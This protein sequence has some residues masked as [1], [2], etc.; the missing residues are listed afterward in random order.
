M[1]AVGIIDLVGHTGDFAEVLAVTA[2]ELA[3]EALGRRSK[4]TVIVLI[5]LAELVNAI[6]HIG[7][8]LDTQLLCLVT[9]AVV[10]ADKSNQTLGKADEADAQRALID[11][12]LH[13][14]V[15]L[16]LAGTVPQLRHEQGELL[17]HSR[18]LVLEAG[19][20]LT[21]GNFQQ[22]VQLGEESVDA[23]LLVLDFHALDSEL[24]DID[25]REREVA[26]TDRGL[27]AEAVLEH[28]GATTHRCHLVDVTFG[29]V[30]T[31]LVILVVGGIEVDE[32]GEKT[33]C[34]HL[35]GELVEV[36]VAVLRLIAHACFLLPDL[37]GEDGSGTVAH[38]LLGRVEQLADDAAPFSTDV[39]TLVDRAE[40]H[41][42]SATGVDRVHVVDE[43]LH[44]LMHTAHRLV[45]GMLQDTLVTLQEIQIALNEVV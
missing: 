39:G 19:I 42:V 5:A 30:D 34:R 17:G 6:T 37:N 40:H 41:L 45:D 22:V 25:G 20:K 11:D 1:V 4:N 9:L 23:F 8:D 27:L 7:N 43:G 12:T 26:T 31:P 44:G 18:L 13:L 38:A 28:T 14:V 3:A 33:T 29:I 24:D 15:G 35:A 10:M 2:G 16:E 32:V 21:C 36:I